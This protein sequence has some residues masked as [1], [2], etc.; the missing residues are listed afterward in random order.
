MTRTTTAMI[1]SDDGRSSFLFLRTVSLH[2]TSNHSMATL[3]S[4]RK[5][6]RVDVKFS[7]NL[8][9]WCPVSGVGETGHFDL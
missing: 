9:L 1:R 4:G 6:C 5:L 8:D 2:V 3:A 7:E